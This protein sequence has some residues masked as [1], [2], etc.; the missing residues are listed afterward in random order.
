M[1]QNITANLELSNYIIATDGAYSSKRN[2]GGIGIVVIK[3]GKVIL[4]YSKMYN[5]TTNNQMELG[6]II[7]ALRLVKNPIK[8]LTIYTD[9]MYCVGTI[10]QNWKRNKNKALWYEFDIQ[11]ERVSKLCKDI[12]FIHV[13]GHQTD[14][15]DT[16]KWNNLADKLAT[17][18]STQIDATQTN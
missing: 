13:R 16:T 5:D 18:A 6:A 9:S 7:I 14:D 12:K 17:N 15:S 2:Q 1:E 10:T 3:D 8:S 11:L 4:K